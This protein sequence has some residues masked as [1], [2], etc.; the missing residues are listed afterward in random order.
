MDRSSTDEQKNHC[1]QKNQNVKPSKFKDLLRKKKKD[2]N[3]MHRVTVLIHS[4]FGFQQKNN[5]SKGVLTA[6]VWFLTNNL[7]YHLPQK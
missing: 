5:A 1:S 6:R 7:T 2:R 3:F 4:L